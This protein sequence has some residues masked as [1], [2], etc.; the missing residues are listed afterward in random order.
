MPSLRA[1]PAAFF[2]PEALAGQVAVVTGGSSGIGK[3]TVELMLECGASVAFCARDAERVAAV[4]SEL[5]ER[6]PGAKIHA[7]A[8]DVLDPEAVKQFARECES[9]FGAVSM[10]INNAG[11]GRMSTF[12]TT[13]DAEWRRELELKFFSVIHPI[14]AF[15]PSLRATRAARGDASIVCVNSLLARQPEP[16]M[17]ATSA[18][19]AGLL[20]LVRSLATEFAPDGVRVNGILVGIVES[21]QWTRRFRQREDPLVAWQAWTQAEAQMRHIP[22]GRFG[23]PAEAANAILFLAS[24]L[25]SYTTGS[26][27]DISGGHSRH[28]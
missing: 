8:C 23:L 20:N 28:A 4:A 26:H 7:Q 21:A 15:L 18:A 19:R 5:R 25:A 12:A 2:S 1:A 6:F 10:L 22:L 17:V 11:Q 3:A 16:H 24:P 9:A 14:R 27:L 13:T